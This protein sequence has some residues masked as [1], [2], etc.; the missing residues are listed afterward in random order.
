MREDTRIRL[1][2]VTVIPIA[3]GLVIHYIRREK[4]GNKTIPRQLKGSLYEKELEIAINVALQAGKNIKDAL[5]KDNKQ[6]DKKGDGEIDFVTATDKGNERLIFTELQRHFPTYNLIGEV[7][8][9]YLFS[10]VGAI[11]SLLTIL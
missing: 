7:S 11:Y 9:S 3:I 2:A 1:L 4:R 5:D 8:S 6:V 10:S